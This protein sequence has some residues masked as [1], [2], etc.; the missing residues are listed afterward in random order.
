MSGGFTGVNLAWRGHA[1]YMQQNRV[2]AGCFRVLGI[3]PAIGREFT[4]DEDRAGGPPAAILS[5]ATSLSLE[6]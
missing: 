2:T 1:Q 5:R 3:S 6:L 4:R